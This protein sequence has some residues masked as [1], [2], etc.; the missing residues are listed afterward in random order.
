MSPARKRFSVAS[1]PPPSAD[2]VVG[3]ETPRRQDVVTSPTRPRATSGRTAFTWR[4]TAEQALAL[5]EMTLRLKRQLGPAKLDKAEMLAA[6]AGLAEENSA[7]FG[8]WQPGAHPPGQGASGRS[9][10]VNIRPGRSRP[11]PGCAGR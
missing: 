3:V 5:D 10:G 9:L 7:V 11:D 1:R 2:E 8:A 4:L 6:L